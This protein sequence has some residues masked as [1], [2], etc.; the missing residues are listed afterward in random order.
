MIALPVDRLRDYLRQLPP[1]ARAQLVAELEAQLA[2]ERVVEPADEPAAQL[3]AKLPVKLAAQLTNELSLKAL[4]LIVAAAFG[5]DCL[6][7]AARQ[8]AFNGSRIKSGISF[9]SVSKKRQE[10]AIATTTFAARTSP[11]PS[12]SSKMNC[13]RPRI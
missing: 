3:A 2:D 4:E 6:H 13:L 12:I 10:T 9:C 5:C 7:D 8:K 1:G 11:T